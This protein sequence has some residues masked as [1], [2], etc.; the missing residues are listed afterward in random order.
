VIRSGPDR[1][2]LVDAGPLPSAVDQCLRRLRV[3][4]LDLVLLTHHHAD[5]VLGLSGALRHRDTRQ[6]LVS[7]L[8]E[9]AGNAAEVHRVAAAAG[10]P[11]VQGWAGAAGGTET[12][13]WGA[14]WRL[15]A[16]AEPPAPPSPGEGGD[17]TAVNESSLVTVAEVTGPGGAVRGIVL[18]D[19]ETDGQ[20]RLLNRLQ[21]GRADAG[22][23]VDVYV[24]PHHGS[25]R[26]EP[27]LCSAL[28]PRVALV[29]VGAD[30]DYGHPAPSTLAMLRGCGVRVHRTDQAGG[31]AL[32]KAPDGQLRVVMQRRPPTGPARGPPTE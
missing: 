17:G 31:I 27:R 19:L 11:V 30:N 28:A 9:P 23:P 4:H 29:G 20:Q 8:A 25:A 26:Q 2:L 21:T 3:R 32:V 13:E 22:G 15:L 6:I 1:A 18:G 10:V 12:G 14:R 7:P 24:V 5:H 16:P